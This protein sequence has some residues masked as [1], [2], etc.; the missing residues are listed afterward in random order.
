MTLYFR[1]T[2]L[3]TTKILDINAEKA[4]KELNENRSRLSFESS[5]SDRI[6]TI[7]FFVF[8]NS[9]FLPDHRFLKS[10]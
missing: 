10:R 8:Q 7:F 2:K 4:L 9:K 1:I 6:Q 3:S 5:K